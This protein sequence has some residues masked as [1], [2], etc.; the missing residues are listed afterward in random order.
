M[1]AVTSQSELKNIYKSHAANYARAALTLKVNMKRIVSIALL[2]GLSGNSLAGDLKPFKSD[3]CSSF[4]DG[5]IEQNSLWLGCCVE[6][7]KAYWAGGT[8]EDRKIADKALKECVA[9]AGEAQIAEI[10]LAGV[11]V[12]GSPYFPTRFR[13]GYGW[14]YLRGYKGL[15]D[16]EKQEVEKMIEGHL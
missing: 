10:M 9:T 11:R 5:T 1:L 15:T 12:G 8:Y 6:H 14:P 4:P 13:W 3:G 7:D 16:I 2:I